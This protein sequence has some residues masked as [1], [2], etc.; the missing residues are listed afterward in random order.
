MEGRARVISQ[1]QGLA[2]M[3]LTWKIIQMM[4][5]SHGLIERL[6]W[7]ELW[8][9]PNPSFIETRRAEQQATCLRQKGDRLLPPL[10]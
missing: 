7:K 2:H 6:K 3:V 10:A 5:Y 9:N 4:K 1:S 8:V